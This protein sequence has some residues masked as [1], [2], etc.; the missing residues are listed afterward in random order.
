M[1]RYPAK[2]LLYCEGNIGHGLWRGKVA[3]VA[4]EQV[5]MNMGCIQTLVWKNFILKG[6][7]MEEKVELKCVHGDMSKCSVALIELKVSGK[8]LTI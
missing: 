8:K 3:G 2:L 1:L 7:I 6:G 4:V 5:F